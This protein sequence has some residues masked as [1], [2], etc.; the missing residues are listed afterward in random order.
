MNHIQDIGTP[1]PLTKKNSSETVKAKYVRMERLNALSDH[2]V[3]YKHYVDNILT[4]IR[5]NND[6]IFFQ[7]D[8][9]N[10]LNTQI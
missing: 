8:V 7:K 6:T 9:P 2:Y 3:E 10:I 1:K 4:V 5:H